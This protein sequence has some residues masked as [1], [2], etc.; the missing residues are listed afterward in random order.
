MSDYDPYK[1]S[2]SSHPERELRMREG[3]YVTVYGEMD[4][5]GYME[6]EIDG[7]Y[8]YIFFYKLSLQY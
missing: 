2:T 1:S 4:I 8:I 6:G 7:E 5:D 3:D